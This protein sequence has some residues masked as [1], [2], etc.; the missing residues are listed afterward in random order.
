LKITSIRSAGASADSG[1]PSRR[2]RLGSFNVRKL[3][4]Y[5]VSAVVFALILGGV[6]LLGA[7]LY[8]QSLAVQHRIRQALADS[9]KM[10]VSIRKTTITPWDGLR[11]DG[12]VARVDPDRTPADAARP[13]FLVANSFRIR[14]GLLP[15]FAGRFVVSEVL[16]DHPQ[17]AWPQDA[18]GRWQFPPEQRTAKAK[19]PKRPKP[20]PLAS[21]ESPPE[22]AAAASPP[23]AP[24]VSQPPAPEPPSNKDRERTRPSHNSMPIA[25]DRL[26]LR[27]GSLDLLDAKDRLIGRFEEV[28]VDGRLPDPAHAS[29]EYWFAKAELPRAD[30]LLTNFHG[31]F[32]YVQDT[33]LDL[34]AGHGE[35]AGGNVLLTYHLDPGAPGSPYR[36]ECHV[37]NVS[38]ARLFAE[39]GSKMQPI[40]GRLEGNVTISGLA[41][42]PESRNATGHFQL[43]DTRLK[44]LGLLQAFGQ[45]LR[46]QDLSQ[47]QFKKADLECQLHG[48]TL[49]L[50]SLS[51]DSRDLQVS[52]HG[53]Y[54]VEEDR[55][56][57]HARLV[58][59]QAVSQE[60]PRFVQANFTPCGD[61]APG[62][63]FIDF[64][65]TGPLSKPSTDLW[66][67][68]LSGPLNG[69][70]ENMLSPKPRNGTKKPARRNPTPPPDTADN[71]T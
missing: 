34:A 59:D 43:L 46:I 24:P 27:H 28:N 4:W 31:C 40:E 65:I 70:F 22:V 37:E 30:L 9:L 61:F 26:R 20:A 21:G 45:A 17:L 16:L 36:A 62:S 19:R 47:L 66:D 29:G 41:G 63:R 18:E 25:V 5:A 33:E 69:L 60:L 1:F 32:T 35:L 13:D 57:L 56:D 2:E 50:Q 67:R 39:A 53:Q 11:I 3:G 8:V 15:L 64:T 23:P 48:S 71:K 12:I 54:L 52:V 42:D 68:A 6:L 38:I 58:I 55:L 10:P 7:N 51:L 49:D 14:F 44:N